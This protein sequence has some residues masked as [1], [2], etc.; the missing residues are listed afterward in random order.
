MPIAACVAALG[1][2]APAAH[3]ASGTTYRATLAAVPLNTPSGAASGTITVTLNG[4]QATISEHVSGLAT[5]LPTDKKTLDALGIPAAFAGAPFPHVQHIHGPDAALGAGGAGTCPTSAADSNH[6][7][8]ITTGEA[9]DNYGPILS[10]LSTAPGGTGDEKSADATNVKIAPGGGSFTYNRTITLSSA[11]QAAITSGKAVI[12][13]HG[14]N[15]ANAPKA[16]LTVPNDVGL[17]LPGASK[18]VAAIATSPALCGVLQASQMSTMPGGGVN[19]GF[20]STKSTT[21]TTAMAGGAAAIAL[22]GAGVVLMR[23]RKHTT[24]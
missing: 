1:A 18:P 16:S 21:N 19:T 11:S 13:V 20:A 4:N 8:L 2:G 3:A 15:P 5:K 24:V 23:R 17:T 12:V 14:L 10:T 9:G 6:D 22:G 7:G